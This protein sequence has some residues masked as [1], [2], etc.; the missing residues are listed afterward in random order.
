MSVMRSELARCGGP[1]VTTIHEVQ[2]GLGRWPEVL[3]EDIHA[4][5]DVLRAEPE[6]WGFM[7]PM[8]RGFQDVY[9]AYTQRAHC[10]AVSSGTASLQLA[11]AASGAEAGDEIIT[12][13]LGFVASAT[14]ILHHNC[15]PVFTE[16]DPETFNID[17][18]DVARRI[19]PRTRA[20]VAVDLLG[21]PANYESLRTLAR[22]HNLSIIED[23][24]QSQGARYQGVPA[25]GLGDISA[26]S[27]MA[28]KNLAA[29]GEGGVITTNHEAAWHRIL[30][31]ASQGMNPWNPDVGGPLRVAMQLGFNL[32]PTP[33]SISFAWSQLRRLP[34]YQERREERVAAFETALGETSLFKKP[35]VPSDR[36]HAWQMYRLRVNPEGVG[37][38]RQHA[39]ALR[40][41]VIFLARAEGGV[42]G[43]WEEQT[44]P[45]MRVFQDQVGYGRGCPWKCHHSSI[46]Y[47]EPFEVSQRIIDEGFIVPI[48]RATHALEMVRTQGRIWAK[49]ESEKEAVVALALKIHEAGG[50]TAA[51]GLDIRDAIGMTSL[52]FNPTNGDIT[53]VD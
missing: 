42:C 1:P 22:K 6:P 48:T 2:A 40:D 50:F 20:I 7:H 51:S 8:V 14:C 3:E 34:F 18:E 13:A 33:T 41:A 46:D 23:A 25:G 29:A 45:S 30:G 19:T 35:K 43:F 32:R 52:R 44:L 17:P 36:T 26:M 5:V 15:I 49:L 27:I 31:L 24:S 47:R 11:V 21:L 9:G 16:V 28:S 53:R 39:S 37:L 10:L 12:P 38:T 4:V